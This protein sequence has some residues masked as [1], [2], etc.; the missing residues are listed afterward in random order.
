[1]AKMFEIPS[2]PIPAVSTE[3]RSMII[4][5]APKVGKTSI[6]AQLPQSLIIELEK[7]G[8]DALTARYINISN[9]NDVIP[10][11]QQVATDPSIKFLILDTISK[12]DRQGSTCPIK[13][14]L[15]G[16]TPEEDNPVLNQVEIFVNA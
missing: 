4:Y 5:A 2:A 7:G 11:L 16:E 6:C 9:P 1:M 12:L 13:I 14:P 8:A 15:N 10:C 3:P